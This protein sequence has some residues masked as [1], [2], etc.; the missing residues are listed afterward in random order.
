MLISNYVGLDI[1]VIYYVCIAGILIALLLDDVTPIISLFIMMNVVISEK[2]SPSEHMRQIGLGSATYYTSTAITV[3]LAVL[4]GLWVL[5]L[6]Y[7]AI[8]MVKNKKFKITPMFFGLCGLAAALMLNG[9][10]GGNYDLRDLA[11]GA[12]IG[13]L[14]L[15]L[16]FVIKD[17]VKISEENFVKIAYYFVAISVLLLVELA[18]TYLTRPVIVDGTF[19]REQIE[20]GWGPCLNMG[21]WLLF[22][23]PAVLYLARKYKYGYLFTGYSI[24]L[25]LGIVLSSAKSAMFGAVIIYPLCLIPLFKGGKNRLLHLFVLGAAALIAIIA[26]ASLWQKLARLFSDLFS[27]FVNEDG[28]LNGNGRMEIWGMA[29]DSFKYGP[30]FGG[31][32]FDNRTGLFDLRYMQTSG[33]ESIIPIFYQNTLLQ[34]LGSCGI[35]GLLA[36]VIHRVQT[37][38]CFFS[39][40]NYDRSFIA[41]VLLAIIGLSLVDCYFFSLLPTTVY[42]ALVAVL[43]AS[44]KKYKSKKAELLAA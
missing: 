13:L 9:V 31:G 2:N 17:N 19:V 27:S 28:S 36:Y 7:R 29:I 20:F 3:Q 39:N 42:I 34:F 5:A 23:I 15:F 43:V 26:A 4:I 6:M 1:F 10:G 14:L 18:V 44:G 21:G 32:F 40:V 41:T 22:C 8:V 11:Y 16:F 12:M 38:A 24:V 37:I 33:I 35:F 25:L 30:V